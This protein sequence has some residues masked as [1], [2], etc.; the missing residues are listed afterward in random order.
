[1]MLQD[2][3]HA[4]G[5][6]TVESLISLQIVSLLIRTYFSVS[7]ALKPEIVWT[8]ELGEGEGEVVKGT[9]VKWDLGT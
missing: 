8:S 7:T 3:G 2:A 6:M 5:I 1:M 9:S 4:L